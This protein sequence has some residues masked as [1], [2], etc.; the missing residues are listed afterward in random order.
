M[1]ICFFIIIQTLFAIRKNLRSLYANQILFK[2]QLILFWTLQCIL[3]W[4]C[5]HISLSSKWNIPIVLKDFHFRTLDWSK[6]SFPQQFISVFCFLVKPPAG[7][8]LW[9]HLPFTGVLTAPAWPMLCSLR[10]GGVLGYGSCKQVQDLDLQEGG[11]ESHSNTFEE[12][13]HHRNVLQLWTGPG[14]NLER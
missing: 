2:I 1:L 9:L 4:S 3:V 12:V 14:G 11:R 5:L 7:W 13:S 8:D 6:V 10:A